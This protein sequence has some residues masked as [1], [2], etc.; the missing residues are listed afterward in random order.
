MRTIRADRA[1][2]HSAINAGALPTGAIAIGLCGSTDE[3]TTPATL[4][5]SGA[6]SASYTSVLIRPITTGISVVGNPA[7]GFGVV[8]LNGADNVTIDGV[9]GGGHTLTIA[10]TTVAGSGTA[11]I[12]FIN[13]ATGNVVT[14]AIVQGSF[15]AAVTT[16]GGTVYLKNYGYHNL[17]FNGAG[18]FRMTNA[19]TP[20]KLA[21]RPGSPTPA[22]R[23]AR[24]RRVTPICAS[25]RSCAS[26]A[27]AACT[28][29]RTCRAS[30]S[31]T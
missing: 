30:S 16:S 27:G 19:L 18:T 13:G 3:G 4:N 31:T 6:G 23:A 1:A 21:Q 17:T 11:T 2:A 29:A 25:T 28:C 15:N 12:R 26:P 10:N 9:N 7:S 22:A 20:T 14:N 8:Q 24:A 5:G